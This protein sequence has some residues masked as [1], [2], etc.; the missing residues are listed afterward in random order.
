MMSTC[1]QSSLH[2][3]DTRIIGPPFPRLLA[4]HRAIAL[5]L[6]LSAT[7]QRIDNILRDLDQGN[8]SVDE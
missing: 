8:T 1:T 2:L 3:T 4:I 6:L 5:I 7:G